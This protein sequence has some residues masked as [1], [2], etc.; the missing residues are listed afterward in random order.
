MLHYKLEWKRR[1]KLQLQI[2]NNWEIH[3][4]VKENWWRY[5]FWLGK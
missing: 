3:C 2:L 5:E 4:L 1:C